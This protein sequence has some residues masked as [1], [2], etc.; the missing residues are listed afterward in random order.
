MYFFYISCQNAELSRM[1]RKNRNADANDNCVIGEEF[2]TYG[3]DL[4]RNF[5]FEWNGWR[6]LVIIK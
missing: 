4:N 6:F 1:W 5:G 2:R 3:V